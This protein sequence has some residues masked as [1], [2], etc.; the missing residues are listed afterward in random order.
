MSP[1]QLPLIPTPGEHNLARDSALQQAVPPF[2]EHLRLDGCSPHT[3]AAFASDLRLVV[4][5]F[6]ET[7]R[8][9]DFTTSKLDHFMTWIETGR[10]V[11]CSRKS[12][13]RRV[14]TL[15]AF[16]KFL[17]SEKVLPD[18]PA[19]ALV[20][21]S[22]AAPLQP[23][24]TDD[25]I[26]H[27]LS[28]TL[29]QRLAEKPDARPDL[30]LRLLLDTGIKKSE[31]MQITPADVNRDEPDR[32]MLVIR[33]KKPNNVYQERKIALDPDWLNVLEEFREQYRPKSVIFDCTPRNLEYV[34]HDTAVAAGVENK[35][36]FEILRWTCAVRDYRRGMD[37]EEMRE[38]MGLS[39]VS[40]R[41]TS[42][43]IIRLAALQ[44]SREST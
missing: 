37:L 25:E 3:I 38:K 34:L 16:F 5:F 18:N 8:L 26:N 39:R 1:K 36:S 13:A 35:I 12:Y 44:A 27:L 43:K 21:R 9:I 32:P 24:L 19:D 42:D 30:L 17:K 10:G 23:I 4:D 11:P 15:K 31:C 6:G 14:T 20:Q 40:W 28:H 33:H 2:L 7:M 41:E 29:A 22:G